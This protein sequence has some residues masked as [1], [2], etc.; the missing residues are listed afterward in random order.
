MKGHSSENSAVILY[1]V[2]SAHKKGLQGCVTV[3]AGMWLCLKLKLLVVFCSR[4][5]RFVI[6]GSQTFCVEQPVFPVYPGI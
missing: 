5:A 4:M 6:L 1:E 3:E 2:N